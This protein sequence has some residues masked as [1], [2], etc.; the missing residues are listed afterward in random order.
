VYLEHHPYPENI[1][2]VIEYAQSS[3]TKDL[4]VKSKVYAEVNIAEYWVINL[5]DKQLIIFRDPVNGEYRSRVIL[6][7]GVITPLAFPDVQIDVRRLV[8]V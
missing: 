1:L 8:T 3:L 6:T 7:Y 4:E 5:R 2:W